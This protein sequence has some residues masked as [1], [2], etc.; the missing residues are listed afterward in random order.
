M[1]KEAKASTAARTCSVE[2]WQTRDVADV[3]ARLYDDKKF[4]C[5][6]D[7]RR[8]DRETD[9]NNHLDAL[10][11]QNKANK[12]GSG[13]KERHW[14]RHRDDWAAA[15]DSKAAILVASEKAE[16]AQDAEMEEDAPPVDAEEFASGVKCGACNESLAKTWDDE[17]DR[18]VFHGVVRVNASGGKDAK[19]R[20]VVHQGCYQPGHSYLVSGTPVGSG[21][22]PRGEKRGEHWPAPKQET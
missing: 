22:T 15:S 20:V 14:F 9:L 4:V 3:V 13:P 1:K 2:E 5:K 19:G 21:L 17:E 7:G 16:A 18:W 6:S 11:E 8:F 10:F 12:D